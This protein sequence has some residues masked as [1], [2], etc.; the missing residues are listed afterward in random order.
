MLYCW[1]ALKNK[2]TSVES[3]KKE[4]R[5][6]RDASKEEI[7]NSSLRLNPEQ[8]M[9]KTPWASVHIKKRNKSKKQIGK[10]VP[11]SLIKAQRM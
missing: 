8:T 10:I 4:R 9:Y 7:P 6:I 5:K 3:R 2:Q 1:V 11:R